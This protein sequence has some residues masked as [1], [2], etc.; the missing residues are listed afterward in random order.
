MKLPPKVRFLAIFILYGI[1]GGAC[2]EVVS[3]QPYL[4]PTIAPTLFIGFILLGAYVGADNAG[5]IQ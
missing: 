4:P 1:L 3:A 2:S 5:W